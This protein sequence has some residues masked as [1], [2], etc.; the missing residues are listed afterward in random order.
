MKKITQIL[1]IKALVLGNIMSLQGQTKE[2][3]SLL[4]EKLIPQ[5]VSW[6]V[7]VDQA[8]IKIGEYLNEKELLLAKEVGVKFPE[9]VR[10]VYVDEVPFPYE[11]EH[12]KQMGLSLGFI[13]KDIKNEAQAFGYSIYVRK[14]LNFTISKLA[15]ELVHVM[16][17]E[18]SDSFFT[19][20][21]QYLNDL[22]KYGYS[23]SPLEIEAF[24]AN[25]KYDG[26]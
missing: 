3:N 12:L 10:I 16:Q 5:Y 13:G 11:N 8:G 24:Q 15:H 20:V 7:S 14:D 6:A 25:K 18:R 17:I 1:I 23:K 21:I 19:Y 22:A 9:K 2:E 4:Y 26:M